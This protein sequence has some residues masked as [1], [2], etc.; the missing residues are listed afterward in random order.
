VSENKVIKELRKIYKKAW[1]QGIWIKEFVGEKGCYLAAAGSIRK[2]EKIEI[3]TGREIDI[4]K[5]TLAN[6][7]F[8]GTPG[9]GKTRKE[10]CE[11]A[12][13]AFKS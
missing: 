4:A 8:L 1:K 2:L 9:Y 10:A 11:N 3:E 12:I 7:V 6:C 5:L 13:K